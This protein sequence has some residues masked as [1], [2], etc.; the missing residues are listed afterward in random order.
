MSVVQ[1]KLHELLCCGAPA[2]TTGSP[3][4]LSDT[5]CVSGACHDL[6]VPSPLLATHSNEHEDATARL[7]QYLK[8]GN[9]RM[10]AMAAFSLEQSM[11]KASKGHAPDS[12][13]VFAVLATTDIYSSLTG[14]LKEGN[15]QGVQHA[16]SSL[17]MLISKESDGGAQALDSGVL[18]ALLDSAQHSS[19]AGARKESLRALSRLLRH[20]H[21]Q[22]RLVAC[23]GHKV[24]RTHSIVMCNV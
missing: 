6:H 24:W 23:E 7:L 12:A 14:L 11:R 10:R 13:P 4:K 17:G 3:D 21:A 9:S 19:S 20:E 8:H 5:E 16:A 18:E 22:E 15:E 1:T 2:R